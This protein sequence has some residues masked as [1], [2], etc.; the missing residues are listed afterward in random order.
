MGE[1]FGWLGCFN[2]RWRINRICLVYEV[3]YKEFAA[4][5]FVLRSWRFPV[6]VA[7]D[8]WDTE[9]EEDY[10]QFEELD[11]VAGEVF[12][13]DCL[14]RSRPGVLP[15]FRPFVQSFWV[16]FLFFVV[17]LKFLNILTGCCFVY[18]FLTAN[19]YAQYNLLCLVDFNRIA[20]CFQL[21]SNA[22]SLK[23]GNLK[24]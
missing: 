12:W 8:C 18:F 22:N 2:R 20:F 9:H 19:G 10:V 23:W 1:L 17:F 5:A 14:R 4:L 24:L 6:A 16:F 13:A 3:N 11:A 21:F 15:N 7:V